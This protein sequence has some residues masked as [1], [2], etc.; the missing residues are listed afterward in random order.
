MISRFN[1]VYRKLDLYEIHSK[2][3]E[4]KCLMLFL[5]QKAERGESRENG[6]VN[7]LTILNFT[8]CFQ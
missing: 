3:Y 6:A 8:C 2:G 4:R 1:F 5:S 7:L